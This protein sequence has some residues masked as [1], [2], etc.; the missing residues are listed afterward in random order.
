MVFYYWLFSNENNGKG[1]MK[2][3][4]QR[5]ISYMRISLTDRCN[6]ACTYCRPEISEHL[7]HSDILSYEEILKICRIAISL[8]V[9]NFKITGGEP[10]IRKGYIQFIQRLKNLSGVKQVTL[11]TNGS[12]FNKSDLNELKQ[13]GIDGINFSIDSLDK[14]EYK[15]ICKKENLDQVLRNLEYAYQI[16]IQVKI[17]CVVTD[18]FPMDRMDFFLNYI[19]DKKIA[20]RFIEFMPLRLSQRSDTIQI[21]ERALISNYEATPYEQKLGNGPAHYYKIASYQGH[22]GFIEALHSK[23]CSTCNRVRLSSIGYLKL[24]LFYPDG[25]DLKPYLND[26]NQLLEIMKQTLLKKPKE[27]NFEKEDSLTIMNQ[28]GG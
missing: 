8:G 20:I 4:Y 21:L 15:N 22:V 2:D 10:T 28:I 3:S 17:N 5:D 25:I 27:H 9:V 18:S 24:C 26:D 23:F 6:Y 7:N 14:I 13:I 11:T 1:F 19:Q 12:L 16:G